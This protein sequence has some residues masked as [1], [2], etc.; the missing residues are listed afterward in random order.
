MGTYRAKEL[1]CNEKVKPMLKLAAEI[2]SR[3]I[4]GLEKDPSKIVKTF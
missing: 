4:F 2:A 1:G 3:K